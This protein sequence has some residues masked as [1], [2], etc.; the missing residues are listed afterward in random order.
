[1][2]IQSNF[3]DSTLVASYGIIF[4]YLQI[5]SNFVDSTLVASYGIIFIYLINNGIYPLLEPVLTHWGRVIHVCV[6]KSTIIGSDKGLSPGWW[7]AII[8][9][10]IWILSIPTLETN[11]S[12]TLGKSRTFSFRKMHL[13]MSSVKW[14][15]F[16]L[17]LNVLIYHYWDPFVYNSGIS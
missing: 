3:V 7:Q 9:T 4:I 11:S 17:G 16:C 2:Q 12:E 6:S 8:W 13:Q 14:Q 10:N 5:Q 1:M 15:P